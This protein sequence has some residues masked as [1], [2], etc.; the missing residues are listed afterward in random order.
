ME[1]FCDLGAVPNTF[2]SNSVSFNLDKATTYQCYNQISLTA[3]WYQ[4]AQDGSSETAI[5]GQTSMNFTNTFSA[6]ASPFLLILKLS[7]KSTLMT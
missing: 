1:C 7:Y 5:S 4:A 6:N 2:S 3:Q